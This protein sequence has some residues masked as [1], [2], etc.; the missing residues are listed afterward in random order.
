M[1]K[2]PLKKKTTREQGT[3]SESDIA[4]IYANP[5]GTLPDLTHL[6]TKRSSRVVFLLVRGMVGLAVIGSLIASLWW[7]WTHILFSKPQTLEAT[8]VLP[9]MVRSGEE[10]T[11][12]VQYEN[13]STV[14]MRDV[15]IAVHTP[16]GFVF[17][18]ATPP[19]LSGQDWHIGTL[20]PAER[21]EILLHGMFR[22]EVPSVQTV[23]AFVSYTPAN[24]HSPFQTISTSTTNIEESVI[25]LELSGPEKV[26][27][28]DEV[29]Y[30]I[31]TA[32]YAS[33]PTK[34]VELSIVLPEGFEV[35]TNTPDFSE[36]SPNMW[37]LSELGEEPV[38]F[39]VTGHFAS[40]RAGLQTI[41]ATAS[42]LDGTTPLLQH[43]SQTQTDVLEGALQFSLIG[44]GGK[45]ELFLD[46]HDRLFLSIPY[47]N[48]GIDSIGNASF[49]LSLAKDG[50]SLLPPIDWEAADLAGG[51][52]EGSTITWNASTHEDLQT[53]NPGTEGAFDVALPLR[54]GQERGAFLDAW[55]IRLGGHFDRLGSLESP[56]TI[57]ATPIHASI[58]SD[59]T[60]QAEARYYTEDGEAVGTG[61]L[62]PVP[63]KVTSYQFTWSLTNSWHD[64]RNIEFTTNLP[65]GVVW[66]G[67][68][69]TSVGKVT[70]NDQSRVL[71]W[72]ID[73]LS[74]DVPSATST[75]TLS[76]SPNESDVGSFIKL[77]NATSV[78]ATDTATNS[79]I[80]RALDIVTTE[81]PLDTNA[82]GKGVVVEE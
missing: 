30:T 65:P 29:T 11:L 33:T 39:S 3:S 77:T 78:R 1:T 20:L 28:G 70:F 23:Q 8:I 64:L 82:K 76:I 25:T 21:Q 2:T 24:V 37:R 46:Q 7:V 56:R 73:T 67:V 54:G 10:V 27:A 18:E 59:L 42:L 32:S 58:N 13:S 51:I 9:A 53:I 66:N 79:T 19:A 12:R 63:K 45:N 69:K 74:K 60:A 68:A 22:S 62:P 47:K 52:L 57:Q 41:Q 15:D 50:S 55:D 75:L 26:L 48:G 36:E 38:S 16:P 34:D 40:D 49:T 17:T 4:A 71:T 44:N 81:L 80:S 14:D 61:P 31:N 43:T 35:T 5:D 72:S 6:D